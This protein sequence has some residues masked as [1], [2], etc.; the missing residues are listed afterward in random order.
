MLGR[1]ISIAILSTV[2]SC[3]SL[4]VAPPQTGSCG[5]DEGAWKELGQ[6][7]KVEDGYKCD[8]TVLK[9]AW[10]REVNCYY[11]CVQCNVDREMDSLE[12]DSKLDRWYRK[13]YI[14]GPAGAALGVAA[15]L[16]LVLAL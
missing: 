4:R 8:S 15:S 1:L 7:V 16:L 2:I 11:D 9:N 10:D 6:C 5:F 14:V 13:W 3:S 12:C